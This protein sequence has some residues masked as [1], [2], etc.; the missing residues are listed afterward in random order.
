MVRWFLVLDRWPNRREGGRVRWEIGRQC[1]AKGFM[2]LIHCDS[3]TTQ[4]NTCLAAFCNSPRS[5]LRM[6]LNLNPGCMFPLTVPSKPPMP[7]GCING[8]LATPPVQMRTTLAC[9]CPTVFAG[10]IDEGDGQLYEPRW[11][12]C[13]CP[14]RAMTSASCSENTQT[15]P[16]VAL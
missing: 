15:T 3:E 14:A 11:P 16:P 6:W 7:C 12:C 4:F 5:L 1:T 9:E 13:C 10:E 8:L 2:N